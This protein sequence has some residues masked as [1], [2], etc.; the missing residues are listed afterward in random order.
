MK[1]KAL[2]EGSLRQGNLDHSL[3]AGEGEVGEALRIN[4]RSRVRGTGINSQQY[5]KEKSIN[6]FRLED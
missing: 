3:A 5:K 2:H 1:G 6:N 4:E